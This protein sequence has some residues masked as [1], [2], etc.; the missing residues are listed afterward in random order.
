M[1]STEEF[2]KTVKRRIEQLRESM[3]RLANTNKETAAKF[4]GVGSVSW[5][6]NA[7][8]FTKTPSR[9]TVR[10]EINLRW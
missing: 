1:G 3:I 5:I 8:D 6:G 10:Q 9:A 2:T 4:G 7:T